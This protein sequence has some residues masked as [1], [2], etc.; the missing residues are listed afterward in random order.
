L[1]LKDPNDPSSN[2]DPE[3]FYLP[4]YQTNDMNFDA[5][6]RAS[7]MVYD[8][9]RVSLSDQAKA[10]WD[11]PNNL[12]PDIRDKIRQAAQ[13]YSQY[14]K[15]VSNQY[16]RETFFPSV[17]DSAW[18]N[19]GLG[20]TLLDI[21]SS[22][23]KDQPDPLANGDGSGGPSTRT[24]YQYTPEKDANQIVQDALHAYLGRA[25]KPDELKTFRDALK[26]AQGEN[27]TVVTDDG[28]GTQTTTGGMNAQV[29]AQ[30]WAK[31]QPGFG[32]YQAA[33][34]FLDGFLKAIG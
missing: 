17:L 23:A 4:V 25:A 34:T 30:D 5:A 20:L 3:K 14:S 2:T 13:R 6:S 33:T 26:N 8:P 16:I 1:G 19:R 22:V 7:I 15:P 27:P 28:A 24:F 29:F 31:S 32:N 12:T 9:L 10:F 21:V 11:N 18:G